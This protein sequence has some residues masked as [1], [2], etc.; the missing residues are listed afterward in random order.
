MT[1]GWKPNARGDTAAVDV[2]H[3]ISCVSAWRDQTRAALRLTP[4]QC[5]VGIPPGGLSLGRTNVL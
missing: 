2:A 4:G 1:V 5:R 3:L